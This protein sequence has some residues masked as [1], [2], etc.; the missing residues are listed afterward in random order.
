MGLTPACDHVIEAETD[1]EV[2]ES[3]AL[4]ARE[5]HSIEDFDREKARSLITAGEP[6]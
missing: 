5:I 3:A 4:H 2:L 1:E 6:R